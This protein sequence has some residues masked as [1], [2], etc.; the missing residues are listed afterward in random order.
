MFRPLLSTGML[1]LA[2]PGFADTFTAD[3]RVDLVTIYPGLAT[4]T[5]LITLDLPAGQHDI[6]VPGLPEELQSCLDE[7]VGE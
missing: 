5:W 1:V 6:I 2:C 7:L 3:A 4:V